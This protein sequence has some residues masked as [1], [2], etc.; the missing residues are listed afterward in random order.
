MKH[1]PSSHG[2]DFAL[3]G[4]TLDGDPNVND[5]DGQKPS[6]CKHGEAVE[7]GSCRMTI[8]HCRENFK[9]F[10]GKVW[11]WMEV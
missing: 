1:A 7:C 11:R 2:P 6:L 5:S 8:S 9:L 10:A 3:C 4:V